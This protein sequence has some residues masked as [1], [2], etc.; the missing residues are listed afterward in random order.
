MELIISADGD[1]R[2]IYGEELNL[3]TLGEIQIRRASHVE[4]D[5]SGRWW[6][7]LSPIGG[8]KLG[9]FTHRRPAIEAEIGWLRTHLQQFM[10]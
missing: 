9:P 1:A 3:T 10:L 6:A 5:P 4:P 8:P 2:C 7:D